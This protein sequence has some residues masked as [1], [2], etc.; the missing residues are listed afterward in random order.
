MPKAMLEQELD[1]FGEELTD[2]DIYRL[3]NRFGVSQ[4]AMDL[5]LQHLG[6]IVEP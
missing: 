3:A 6:L 5:R 4:Q 2:M 1:K